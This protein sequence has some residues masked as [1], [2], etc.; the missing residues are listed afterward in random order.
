[1]KFE[2]ERRANLSYEEFRDDYLY[3]HKPVI[4]TDALRNWRAVHR[5]SPDFFKQNFGDMKFGINDDLKKYV[6]PDKETQGAVDYTMGKFIDDVLASTDERP[7]YYFRNRIFYDVFPTLRDDVGPLPKYFFPNWLPDQYLLKSV[8]AVFNRGAALEIY[9]GGKGGSFP[10]LHYDGAGTYAFLIYGQKQFVL[11]SPDQESYSYP[12][13]EKQNLSMINR[14]DNPDLEKFPLFSR[15]E[16]TTFV[17]EPGELAFIPSHWWHT[18][19]MLTPSISLSV[20]VVNESNWHELVD[21]VAMRRH[22]PIIAI[23]S[24]VYLGGAGAWRTWRDHWRS[25]GQKAA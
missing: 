10:V 9:I 1:M 16:P 3:S 12:S 7:S 4:V 17:L 6:G 25:R 20:N 8:G 14:I 24:R 15:A 13:L 18:T 5:W 23:A 21:D 19:K 22:N 2:I 11:Y